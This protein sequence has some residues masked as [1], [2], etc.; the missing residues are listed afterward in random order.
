LT[1]FKTRQDNVAAPVYDEVSGEPLLL[2]DGSQVSRALDG[3]VSRG[4]E[5]EVTGRLGDE[6]QTS[7]G[8][9]RTLMHDATGASVRTYIPR[10]LL[11]T[12]T[13]W[14]PRTW[15]DGL[16]LGAGFNWQS[17][18]STVVGNPAGSAVL[19]QSSVP[20]LSLMAKY[21]FSPSTSLQFNANSVFD[22]KYYVLDEYDNTYYG[23][24]ASVSL[25]LHLAF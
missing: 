14:T 21:D 7:L 18:S 8:F 23:A 11:R 12:F 25:S 4:F 13:T 22:R 5:L 16:T 15:A 2:P 6:W 10:T 1:L 17:R 3:T 19:E 9:S 20:Q 24:P